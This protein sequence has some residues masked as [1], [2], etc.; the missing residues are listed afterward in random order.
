M[1]TA[2]PKIHRPVAYG[3][4]ATHRP[5]SIAGKIQ[6]ER[7]YA[8]IHRKFPY[9]VLRLVCRPPTTG[10]IITYFAAVVKKNFSTKFYICRI[11]YFF[12]FVKKNFSTIFFVKF[13]SE[14][15]KFLSEFVKKI[16][17]QAK[18]KTRIFSG[19]LSIIVRYLFGSKFFSF[20][21]ISLLFDYQLIF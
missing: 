3:L 4:D 12:R 14:F 9:G 1:R 19:F 5:P 17:G 18:M 6:G 21:Q 11:A 8:I 13:L 15:V 10:R 16:T 7:A 2:K 20:R